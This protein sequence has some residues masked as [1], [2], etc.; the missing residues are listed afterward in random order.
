[1]C[2]GWHYGRSNLDDGSESGRSEL[3]SQS[4]RAQQTP[5]NRSTLFL[6]V[7]PCLQ[8]PPPCSVPSPLSIPAPKSSQKVVYHMKQPTDPASRAPPLF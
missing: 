8:P 1:M 4:A 3:A 5:D 7:D 2:C 6:D